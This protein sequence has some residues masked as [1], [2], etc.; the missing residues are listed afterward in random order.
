VNTSEWGFQ[1]RQ[2]LTRRNFVKGLAAGSMSAAALG[3]LS[4]CTNGTDTEAN[5]SSPDTW[6]HEA[7][8]VIIGLGCAGAAAAMEVV[9]SGNEALVLEKMPEETAGGDSA[10]NGGYMTLPCYT[11]TNMVY[12]SFGEM[13][14]EWAKSIEAE[15]VKIP[16]WLLEKADA[17]YEAGTE[18]DAGGFIEGAGRTVYKAIKKGITELNVPVLYET[19]AKKLIRDFKSGEIKG[20]QAEQN[21]KQ[22][23]I[24]ARKAVLIA[25]GSYTA[26]EDLVKNFHLP[27][28][29][30]FTTGAP[31]DTG[32]GLIMGLEAGAALMMM[33]MSAEWTT[34]VFKE[35]SEEMGLGISTTGD[36]KIIVNMAG[37]RFMNERQGLSHNKSQLPFLAFDGVFPSY[38]GYVNL[39]M[40]AVYDNTM[41]N[42]AP[43]GI[44]ITETW[45]TRQTWAAAFG[46]YDWSVDNNTE[47]ERGWILKA[48]TL[49][50]LAA[51]MTTRNYA[52][53]EVAMDVSSFID[54]IEQYNNYCTNEV[55]PEFGKPVS[56]LKPLL[57]PPFY[58]AELSPALMYT[59]GGLRVNAL[60][61]TLDFS[62]QPIPRLYSAGN[63]GQGVQTSP[64][65]I[66]ACMACGTLAARHAVALENW[67]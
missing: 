20:V 14:L 17:Q 56:G 41:V 59:I 33:G 5:A 64:Y 31:A 44:H 49:E 4:S 50:E 3:T 34:F 25:T 55:D 9:S 45:S 29:N 27:G 30:Y 19:P 10:C 28:V 1:K 2:G 6:D 52:G 36:A 38:R 63:V 57:E 47:I 11:A 43:L 23:S 26:N 21:G 48:D 60:G 35:A 7:D 54:T 65:S 8:I 37:K 67:T 22:I 32:D 40:F 42:A 62:N 12:Y 51:K 18:S 61:Q 39:P 46:V 66:P 15:A 53:Q 24:K 16:N 13:D 58:A